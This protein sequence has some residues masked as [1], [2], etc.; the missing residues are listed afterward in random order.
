MKKVLVGCLLLCL[1]MPYTYGMQNLLSR[2]PSDWARDFQIEFQAASPREMAEPDLSAIYVLESDFNPSCVERIRKN[3]SSYGLKKGENGDLWCVHVSPHRAQRV[4]S[5]LSVPQNA[6]TQLLVQAARTGDTLAAYWMGVRF[7][8][9]AF[10]DRE[11]VINQHWTVKGALMLEYAALNGRTVAGQMLGRIGVTDKTVPLAI[12][13]VWASKTFPRLFMLKWA[14]EL[15]CHR[16]VVFDHELQTFIETSV[17]DLRISERPE[18]IR[19]VNGEIQKLIATKRDD[20]LFLAER[21]IDL[22]QEN[23]IC[24][25]VLARLA[26]WRL[27]A[28]QDARMATSFLTT[29]L[30]TVSWHELNQQLP[31]WTEILERDLA[32]IRQSPDVTIDQQ[33]V[34]AQFVPAAI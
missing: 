30:R 9:P 13:A 10:K 4:V 20:D 32:Q 18:W 6:P 27:H 17:R 16:R 3:R 1:E 7:L 15:I 33:I 25:Q 12:S 28:C 2:S 19:T 22:L 14:V 8:Q 5:L 34:L 11:D 26:H 31:G 29:L 21:V 23:E 24:P